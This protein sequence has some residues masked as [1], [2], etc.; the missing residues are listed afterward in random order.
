MKITIPVQALTSYYKGKSNV[1]INDASVSTPFDP[2]K[3]DPHPENLKKYKALWDTGATGTCITQKVV[4][5]CGLLPVSRTKVHHADGET[6]SLV[7]LVSIFLPSNVVFPQTR[8]IKGKL[9]GNVDLL[10]GMDIIGSGDFAVTNF[11]GKTVF[12]YR[13]P[14]IECIDFVKD[15]DERKALEAKSKIP[16]VGRNQPCPCGSGKKYKKCCINK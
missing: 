13:A 3:G 5:E 4:D 15:L 6:T 16:K 14:S 7:Y 2:A 12:S 9:P 11:E 10:I 1:L 8:V